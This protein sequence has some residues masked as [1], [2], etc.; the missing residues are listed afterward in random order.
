M[1][2]NWIADF[3]S[4][5]KQRVVICRAFSKWLPVTSGF[6]QGSVLG[7]TLFIIYANDLPDVI[8]SYSGIFADDTTT[9]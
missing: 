3:L 7:P 1:I 6:P 8:Q 2:L 9:N 5:R 4:N